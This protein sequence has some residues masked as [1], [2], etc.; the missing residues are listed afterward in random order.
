MV[1]VLISQPCSV[2]GSVNTAPDFSQKNQR[3]DTTADTSLLN[4]I[5]ELSVLK[6]YLKPTPQQTP[7]TKTAA[8]KQRKQK[9]RSYKSEGVYFASQVITPET[10]PAP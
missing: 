7:Q 4:I 8:A 1:S 9:S 5:Y 2:R 10:T 6:I 3:R